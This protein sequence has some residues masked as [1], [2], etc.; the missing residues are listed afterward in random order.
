MEKQQATIRLEEVWPFWYVKIHKHGMWSTVP[1][2]WTT[3]D[4]A[5]KDLDI[6]KG[7]LEKQG[8]IVYNWKEV[9]VTA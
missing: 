9:N 1:V 7:F 3:R 5:L 4:A 6:V 8:Y 2:R